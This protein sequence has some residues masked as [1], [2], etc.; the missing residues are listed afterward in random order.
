M[1]LLLGLQDV[2][3]VDLIALLRGQHDVEDELAIGAPG[4][5]EDLEVEPLTWDSGPDCLRKRH[6]P[7]FH[8]GGGN[9]CSLVQK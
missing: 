7:L 5:A 9:R 4:A 2:E 3:D 6:E 8:S 1:A